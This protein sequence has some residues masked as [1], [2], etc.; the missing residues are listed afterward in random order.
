M[1]IISQVAKEAVLSVSFEEATLRLETN[2]HWIMEKLS[3]LEVHAPNCYTVVFGHSPFMVGLM[4]CAFNQIVGLDP[5]R[6]FHGRDQLQE[7]IKDLRLDFSEETLDALY[8]SS[9]ERFGSGLVNC[10]L[11]IMSPEQ[12]RAAMIGLHKRLISR[13]RVLL[14]MERSLCVKEHLELL[15]EDY[16]EQ[17][18]SPYFMIE[19]CEEATWDA[20]HYKIYQLRAL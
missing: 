9:K 2:R 5:L 16:F 11:E 13:G 18:I 4:Q 6:V 1:V 20:T 3:Y 17:L 14:I 10:S 12:S 15:D 8:G 7:E 19:T